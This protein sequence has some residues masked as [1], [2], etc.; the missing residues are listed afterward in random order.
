MCRKEYRHI[1]FSIKTQKINI[2]TP[3][4]KERNPNV[5]Q[6]NGKLP[7]LVQT[8]RRTHIY[9]LRFI[10]KTI[11][12]SECSTTI[13]SVCYSFF[14]SLISNSVH[15]IMTA[16]VI[17]NFFTGLIYIYKSF[18]LENQCN[19]I[20]ITEIVLLMFGDKWGEAEQYELFLLVLFTTNH[21]TIYNKHMTVRHDT[22]H[23]IPC[24]HKLFFWTYL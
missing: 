8:A 5:Q 22:A 11:F 24:H 12:E 23:N 13:D 10:I 4:S 14:T 7:V 19:T 17:T 20:L 3:L 18:S 9:H 1:G 21:L 16:R 2:K 15:G 6:K